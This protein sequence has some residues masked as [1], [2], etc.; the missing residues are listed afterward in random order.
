MS[1]HPAFKEGFGD[2][3]LMLTWY[4][5]YQPNYLPAPGK[6]FLLGSS[7][8]WLL[9]FFDSSLWDFGKLDP[10]VLTLWSSHLL[11]THSKLS[12][13]WCF[14]WFY[15]HLLS[16]CT[17]RSEVW[18]RLILEWTKPNSNEVLYTLLVF[19][20]CSWTMKTD[21]HFFHT[22]TILRMFLLQQTLS[23]PRITKL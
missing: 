9:W 2:W 1:P 19:L 14:C 16:F 22:G 11:S 4:T 23:Y 7:V 13:M 17:H 10:Y 15:P 5:V 6:H 20:L 8:I 21:S 3:D 12:S 18:I